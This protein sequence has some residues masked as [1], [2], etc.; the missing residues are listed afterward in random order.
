MI[1]VSVQ[2]LDESKT[3]DAE[4]METPTRYILRLLSCPFPGVTKECRGFDNP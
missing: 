2:L 3:C 4:G 1:Y